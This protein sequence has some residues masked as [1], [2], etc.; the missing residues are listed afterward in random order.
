MEA[1]FGTGNEM[2]RRM[3]QRL[4]E[5]GKKCGFEFQWSPRIPNT[6]P[7]HCLMEAAAEGPEQTSQAVGNRQSR[8]QKELF[9]AYF[10]R[11][12]DIGDDQVLMQC[13]ATVGF[14]EDDVMRITR[15]DRYKS[16]VVDS[17]MQAK[18]R[19]GVTGVPA[20]IFNG[21]FKVSG[22]QEETVLREV[23]ED[24]LE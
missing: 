13:A 3:Q 23:L 5:E 20:L 12:Q 18:R 24:L 16:M 2:F 15:D 22:A 19:F 4:V 6:V 21:R 17:D 11:G 14:S 8:L 10:V 9:D 1:K 7:A